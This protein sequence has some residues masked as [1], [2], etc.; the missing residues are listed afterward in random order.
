MSPTDSGSSRARPDLVSLV[1][2]RSWR[3]LPER[4]DAAFAGNLPSTVAAGIT[5]NK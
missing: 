1:I 4:A 2:C 5:Q 3:I